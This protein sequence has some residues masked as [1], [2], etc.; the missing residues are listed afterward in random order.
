MLEPAPRTRTVFVAQE[1]RDATKMRYLLACPE[2]PLTVR[3]YPSADRWH[4]EARTSDA[5]DAVVV[6]AA[7][8]SRAAALAE[9]GRWWR[10][11]E[12]T[13]DL[14]HLDWEAITRALAEVR[15]V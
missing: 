2:S 12:K 4:V 10:A 1:L 8:P 13:L 7:G 11:Q 3:M 5:A 6:T 9:V 14:P 15:A